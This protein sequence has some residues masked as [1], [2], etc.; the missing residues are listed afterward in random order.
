METWTLSWAFRNLCAELLMPPGIWL[1]L[2][3][4][5]VIFFRKKVL[6][7]KGVL[8]F[9]LTMI[10][11]TCTP[12]FSSALI[13]L[14]NPLMN[15]PQP[16]QLQDLKKVTETPGAIVILGSG[17]RRGALESAQYN[18]Q[19]LSKQTLE[20]TRYGAQ[21]AKQIGLAVLVSG[22]Q[23]D[24]ISDADQAEALVMSA[25]MEQEFGVKVTWTEDQSNTTQENALN[26]AR[27]L[28]AHGIKRIYLVTHFWHMPRAVMIFEQYGFTVIPAPHGYE[29]SPRWQPLD[30]YPQQLSKTREIW[31]EILGMIWYRICF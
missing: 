7:Q 21:L 19:D 1:V 24:R 13:H 22:G 26:S 17:R 25:V 4:W 18:F 6:W 29:T 20:R 3:L 8:F 14:A 30:F 10:W 28:K 27:I 31:H 11:V 9:A 16:L 5:A 12:I 23:P 2:A 15:W